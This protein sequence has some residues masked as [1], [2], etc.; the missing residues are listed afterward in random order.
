M[1]RISNIGEAGVARDSKTK[2]KRS[3]NSPASHEAWT[4]RK[5]AQ[6]RP[7]QRWVT[8]ENSTGGRAGYWTRE[9]A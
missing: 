6:A 7:R 9:A 2:D 1:R 8:V 3:K 5:R 4:A